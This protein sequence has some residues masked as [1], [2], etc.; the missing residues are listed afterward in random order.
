MRS[1]SPRSL[2]VVVAMA[3]L[4][5]GCSRRP[6]RPPPADT[7]GPAGRVAAIVD[8]VVIEAFQSGK[9]MGF[10]VG[11]IADRQ[12]WGRGYG[13]RSAEDPTP[14]DENSIFEIGSITKVFTSALL[15]QMVGAGEVALS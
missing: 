4:W 13:R 2:V 8:P 11:A 6:P 5:L 7:S 3:S 12:R 1:V 9:Y 10:Y 15:A 14:P